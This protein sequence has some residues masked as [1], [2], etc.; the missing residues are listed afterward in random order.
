MPKTLY[1]PTLYGRNG[2]PMGKSKGN[3][4]DIPVE[5]L[6]QIVKSNPNTKEVY[7]Y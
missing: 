2:R 5:D 6:L 4:E 1:T 7:I 3:Y